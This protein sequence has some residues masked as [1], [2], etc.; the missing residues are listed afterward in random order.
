MYHEE[1]HVSYQYYIVVNPASKSGK[2]Q[3]IWTEAEL[4]S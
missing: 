1:N 3:R 4:K 2:G